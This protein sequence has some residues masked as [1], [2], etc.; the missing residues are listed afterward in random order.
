MIELT[1]E[2][3]FSIRAFQ[4]QIQDMTQEQALSFMVELYT[5]MILK[6]A[7]YKDLLKHQWGITK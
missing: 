5:Q 2:Q 6:E 3:Q 1:T 4:L 7:Y